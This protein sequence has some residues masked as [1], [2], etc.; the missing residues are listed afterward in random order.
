MW[1]RYD[2][3][4]EVPDFKESFDTL[5][6]AVQYFWKSKVNGKSN[7]KLCGEIV[8]KETGEMEGI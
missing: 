7:F 3:I 4:A 8:N 6:S 5:E 2:R 1:Y